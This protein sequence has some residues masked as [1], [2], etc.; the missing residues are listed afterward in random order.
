MNRTDG[1]YAGAPLIASARPATDASFFLAEGPLWDPVRE[2]VLWVD[3]MAGVV[4]TGSLAADGA[5]VPQEAVE[6]PDTTGTVAVSEEGDWIVAGGHRLWHRRPDG[7][8]APGPLLVTGDGRRFNDGK[9][10]PAGRLLVGTKGDGDELLIS[11]GVDGRAD[12]IDEDLTL[13]NGLGWSGDGR[14]LY[15]VDTLARVIHVRDYDPE[16]G[17]RGTRSIFAT[18]ADGYPDGM[19]VDADDHLWVAVWG[20]GCVL[21]LDP[22]GRIVGRVDVDA[23]HVS[24]VAFAGPDLDTLVITTALEGLT[25]DQHER[26]PDA[27]RLF[28]ATPG[29]IGRPAYWWAGPAADTDT[30]HTS[31]GTP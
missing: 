6:F 1:L 10:D 25:P 14:R 8:T 4:H 23:P 26:H 7:H 18:L 17:A 30:P 28:T 13:A 19:T 27:G 9:A 11:V 24:S 21:R 31:E 5:I 16:T 12:V 20:G 15:S 2:R 3:I 29:V 22:S